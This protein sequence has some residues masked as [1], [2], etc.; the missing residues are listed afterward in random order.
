MKSIIKSNDNV[1]LKWTVG[2]ALTFAAMSSA[3]AHSE[4]EKVITKD[5]A[6][7]GAEQLYLDAHIGS[8]KFTP[9]SDNQI[10]VYVKVSEKEGWGIFKDSPLEAEL[11]V[12]RDGNRVTLSLNDDEYGEEWRIELPK[13]T[14][15]NADLGVGELQVRNINS[16]L[17]LDVGVGEAS[18]V[19][20]ASEFLSAKGQ[21]GVGAATV[22]SHS[23]TTTTDRAMVSED[24]TWNGS[25]QYSIDVEVGVGDISIKLD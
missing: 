21:A 8:V 1:L 17:K 14:L 9:S 4:N 11:V 10:H 3:Y 2:A 18:V 25:G 19:V 7:S 12:L 22:R 24:V 13:M 16:N 23:G 6:V 20:S 5:I 15:L